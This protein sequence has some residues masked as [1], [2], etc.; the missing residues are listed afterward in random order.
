MVL[1]LILPWPPSENHY[2]KLFR[3]RLVI[4]K[5]G[6]EYKAAVKKIVEGKGL[7][8]PLG[9]L[10]SL[11]IITHPKTA[12]RYDLDN[13]LKALFDSMKNCVYVDDSQVSDLRIRR[14]TICRTGG[15]VL[16]EAR[17]V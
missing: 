16:V 8:E 6:R 17:E 1:C 7:T 9:G 13:L 4:A 11:T 10:V 14:G 3:G 5:A 12:M 15:F 2:R